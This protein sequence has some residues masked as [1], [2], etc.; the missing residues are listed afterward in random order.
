VANFANNQS[1]DLASEVTDWVAQV[2]DLLVRFQIAIE[3]LQRE[4]G[5]ATDVK[6]MMDE[7]RGRI[8][9]LRV[10]APTAQSVQTWLRVLSIS[11]R[12]TARFSDLA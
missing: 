6:Q 7:L 9:R 10:E 3:L 11:A 4:P 2:E 1:P 12:G 8:R 5:V